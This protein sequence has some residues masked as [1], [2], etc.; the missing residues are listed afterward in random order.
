VTHE[1]LGF[2]ADAVLW[3]SILVFDSSLNRT[4]LIQE[5]HQACELIRRRQISVIDQST[6]VALCR[7]A[8]G[9]LALIGA[10][11]PGRGGRGS[12]GAIRD[13]FRKLQ[14]ALNSTLP[15]SVCC[16][17]IVGE[18]FGNYREFQDHLRLLTKLAALRV[19]I[20]IGGSIPW[21]VIHNR[22]RAQ[23]ELELSRNVVALAASVREG[24]YL[25]FLKLVDVIA[26]IWRSMPQANRKEIYNLLLRFLQI[27][28]DFRFDDL[29][30][31]DDWLEKLRQHGKQLFESPT[32]KKKRD[33]IDQVVAFMDRNYMKDIGVAQ[34]AN[35]LELTPNYLSQRFHEKTGTT[36][37]RY[38]TRLRMTK[39]RELLADP[40]QQIQQIARKVGYAS[41]RHFSALFKLHHEHTPS[42]YRKVRG[43]SSAGFKA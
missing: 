1:A 10:W 40:S 20:G 43:R 7:L 29:L 18:Q 6:R 31:N 41:S 42:D 39:A 26:G 9:Q 33:I 16:T 15:Q 37:I 34:I 2:V 38:L 36:F 25:D 12:Y 19:I 14:F 22:G 35:D 21:D 24:L 17:V 13:L 32:A 23:A 28:L 30:G 3:G 4:E 11:I 27:T 5:E 8:E